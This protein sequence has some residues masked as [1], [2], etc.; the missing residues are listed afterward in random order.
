MSHWKALTRTSV[1]IGGLDPKTA[2][3]MV[4]NPG[5]WLL[6][7]ANATALVFPMLN[8]KWM[9]PIG[10]T[11]TS[12]LFRTLVKSLFGLDVTNPT[13]RVPSMTTK[14]SVPRGWM[15]GG[16]RPYGAKSRRAKDTPRVLRPGNLSTFTRLTLDPS[17][18]AA[19]F[20][21][22]LSPGKKK[23]FAVTYAGSL[24]N[25]PFTNTTQRKLCYCREEDSSVT[26]DNNM[27]CRGKKKSNV[28]DIM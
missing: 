17:L 11:K 5:F 28:D 7:P 4:I 25:F 16:F 21:G 22:I 19:V 20:P 10:N 23:S 24:Q 12:P 1:F 6:R 14:S 3:A 13:K 15:W 2:F 27:S 26:M 8:W 9:R 18:F